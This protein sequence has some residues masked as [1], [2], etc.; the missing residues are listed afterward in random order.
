MSAEMGSGEKIVVAHGT[1]KQLPI[2]DSQ[3][4]RGEGCGSWYGE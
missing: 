1:E 3:I 4:G 2:P